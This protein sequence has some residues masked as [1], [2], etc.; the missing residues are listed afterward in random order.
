MTLNLVIKF[1]N[2][3]F[4]FGIKEPKLARGD[5]ETQN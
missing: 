5:E 2:F 3:K 4:I 1:G